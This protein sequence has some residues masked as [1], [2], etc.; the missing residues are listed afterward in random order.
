M[1]WK[2]GVCTI[3][4]MN[5]WNVAF[6]TPEKILVTGTVPLKSR[7][8]NAVSFW[9]KNGKGVNSFNGTVEIF[10]KRVL[11]VKDSC[12]LLFFIQEGN[13]LG[14]RHSKMS[15]N[16]TLSIKVGSTGMYFFYDKWHLHLAAIILL[17]F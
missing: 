4:D 15:L 6:S 8:R 2:I 3:T 10:S 12:D 16:R 17:T 9:P 13:Q 14:A 5:S 11:H 1:F 7:E